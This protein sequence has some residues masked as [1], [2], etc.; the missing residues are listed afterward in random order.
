MF[1]LKEEGNP[2][3]CPALTAPGDVMC[4]KEGGEQRT[5]TA[6]L[7]FYEVPTTVTQRQTAG[8]RLQG[9]EDGQWGGLNGARFLV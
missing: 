2:D 6:G 4:V 3:T 1:S 8:H 9:A 7:Q 5:D